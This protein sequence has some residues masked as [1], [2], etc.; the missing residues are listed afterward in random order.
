MPT[1]DL[2]TPAINTDP[3]E[4]GYRAQDLVAN[5]S[6]KPALSDAHF[7]ITFQEQAGAPLPDL[8]QALTL[9]TA[10]PGLSPRI[11]YRRSGRES[12]WGTGATAAPF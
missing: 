10:P 1:A 3:L 8:F 11:P 2:G 5:P 7:Q 6:L 9:G 4:L 12:G